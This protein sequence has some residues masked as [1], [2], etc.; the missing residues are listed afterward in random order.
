MK[1]SN[2]VSFP[3]SCRSGTIIAKAI[4]A[5]YL[6]RSNPFES[7]LN[8]IKIIFNFFAFQLLLIIFCFTTSVKIT[9]SWDFDYPHA[10]Q[11]SLK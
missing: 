4:F 10:D 5:I 1:K 7:Q 9:P 6:T 2:Y 8:Q 11:N 3:K